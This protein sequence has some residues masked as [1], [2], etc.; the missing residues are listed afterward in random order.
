MKTTRLI[1]LSLALASVA[2]PLLFGGRADAVG[3]IKGSAIRGYEIRAEVEH[4]GSDGNPAERAYTP[5]AEFSEYLDRKLSGPYQAVVITGGE[6]A[7]YSDGESSPFEAQR[8]ASVSKLITTTAVMRL[9]E[10]GQLSLDTPLEELIEFDIWQRW[11][12]VTVLDLL[13]QNS[14]LPSDRE[15]WFGGRW[16]T[17]QEA[18]EDVLT[19]GGTARGFYQYSNSNFCIL[20]LIV[21]TVTGEDFFTAVDNLVFTLQMESPEIDPAY[22]NL[23]GAG[24]FQVSAI[25]LAVFM[26]ALQ[27]DSMT[28]PG[29]LTESTK[30]FMKGRQVWNYG[31]GTWIFND[32]SWGHSGT[33]SMGRNIVV[34]LAE[35]KQIVVIQNQDNRYAS[36]LD[37]KPFAHRIASEHSR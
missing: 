23:A 3:A 11:N 35:T 22:L 2:L 28:A 27:A 17:C 25:D 13:Q 21:E 20:S 29:F 8:I 1:S 16:A 31:T 5:E 26:S 7:L 24:Y 4:W 18:A 14:G 34:E 10:S 30:E 33:L 36:G 19:S 12:E 37:L 6:V 15:K 9:A 32:G